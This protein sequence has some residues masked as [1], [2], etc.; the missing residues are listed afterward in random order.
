MAYMHSYAN[1]AGDHFFFRMPSAAV[2]GGH[3]QIQASSGSSDQ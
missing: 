1:L 3:N 2:V